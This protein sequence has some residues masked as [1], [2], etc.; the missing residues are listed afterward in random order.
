MVELWCNL[1]AKFC[2]KESEIR[3][4][5]LGQCKGFSVVHLMLLKVTTGLGSV[6]FKRYFQDNLK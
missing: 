5:F 6:K 1:I 2:R 3:K 4:Y